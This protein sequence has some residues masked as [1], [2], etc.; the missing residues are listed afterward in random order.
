M[1]GRVRLSPRHRRPIR[2]EKLKC[3]ENISSF[4]YG[5]SIAQNHAGSWLCNNASQLIHGSLSVTTPSPCLCPST[6]YR[7]EGNMGRKNGFSG[8]K[9]ENSSKEIQ[10]RF[11]TLH[12]ISTWKFIVGVRERHAVLGT[13]SQNFNELSC[14]TEIENR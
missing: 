1:G 9:C 12:T 5:N 6:C 2:K 14:T 13:Q 10:F 11:S 3:L 8:A 4:L 7:E